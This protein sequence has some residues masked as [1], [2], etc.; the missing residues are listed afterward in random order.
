METIFVVAALEGARAEEEE[1]EEEKEAAAS[2]R[3]QGIHLWYYV[4]HV[5][6]EGSKLRE[7][8]N[9]KDSMSSSAL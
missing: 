6:K 3:R 1:E 2:E 8:A 5:R 7:E 9:S 4:V